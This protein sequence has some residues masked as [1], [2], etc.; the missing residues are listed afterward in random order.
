MCKQVSLWEGQKVK[1][2]YKNFLHE[3]GEIAKTVFVFSLAAEHYLFLI[4]RSII[5][6]SEFIES[7]N[8]LVTLYIEIK[9]VL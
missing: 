4:I 8:I 6:I 3:A 7:I 2:Y 1:F 9:K 5:Y